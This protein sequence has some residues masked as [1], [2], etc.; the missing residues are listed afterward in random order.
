V[1][2]RFGSDTDVPALCPACSLFVVPHGKYGEFPD[3]TSLL[4]P[5]WNPRRRKKWERCWDEVTTCSKACN[6]KRKQAKQESKKA[7]GGS[8]VDDETN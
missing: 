2:R 7:A 1:P 3:L 8:D 6:G 5:P 4:C